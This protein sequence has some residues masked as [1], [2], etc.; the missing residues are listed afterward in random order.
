MLLAGGAHCSQALARLLGETPRSA[1]EQ[2]LLQ[3]S[4]R[5]LLLREEIMVVGFVRRL[6][7]GQSRRRREVLLVGHRDHYFMPIER[8]TTRA[9]DCFR[10]SYGCCDE[11]SRAAHRELAAAA[12]TPSGC[13]VLLSRLVMRDWLDPSTSMRIRVEAGVAPRCL[14]GWLHHGRT[15]FAKV[16]ARRYAH[17]QD[18]PTSTKRAYQIFLWTPQSQASSEQAPSR[19]PLPGVGN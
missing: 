1:R 2:D 10:A 5:D 15:T 13:I 14:R 4:S 3:L 8:L 18:I 17:L 12:A 16:A 11:Q 7:E 6:H 19:R 9:V